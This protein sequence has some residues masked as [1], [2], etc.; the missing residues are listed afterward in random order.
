MSR[1]RGWTEAE[2]RARG[3]TRITFRTRNAHLLD[4]LRRDGESRNAA[5]ERIINEETARHARRKGTK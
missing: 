5:L 2:F 1:A 3:Y 4:A